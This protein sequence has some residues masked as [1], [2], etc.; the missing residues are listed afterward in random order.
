MSVKQNLP[1]MR[2]FS[3]EATNF[4]SLLAVRFRDILYPEPFC[5]SDL[6][7]FPIGFRD[8]SRAAAA[9]KMER[10]VIIVN[11]F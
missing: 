3:N 7:V 10:F 4:I 9:A 5:R 1:D 11:G 2:S 8:R 6:P